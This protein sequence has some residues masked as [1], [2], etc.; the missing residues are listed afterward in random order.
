MRILF[1]V[2]KFPP[3]SDEN[4][5]VAFSLLS[6]YARREDNSVIDVVTS[7]ADGNFRQEQFSQSITLY[8]V[9]SG[10]GVFSDATYFKQAYE[11]ACQLIKQVSYDLAHAFT[12]SPC[13][14]VCV[15]IKKKF[16]IPYVVSLRWSDLEKTR[17]DFPFFYK[18]TRPSQQLIWKNATFVLS[19]NYAL[20]NAVGEID[21]AKD[22]EVIY[23]GIDT[24]VFEEFSPGVEE[25]SHLRLIT[26]PELV[27]A[28]GIRFLVKAMEVLKDQ[29]PGIKLD[30]IGQGEEEKSL[31]DLVMSLSMQDSIHFLGKVENFDLPSILSEHEVC[32]LPTLEESRV[33]QFMLSAM[34]A[35]LA[36]VTTNAFCEDEYVK[37]GINGLFVVK[38]DNADLERKLGYLGENP[39][40]VANMGEESGLVADGIVWEKIAAQYVRFYS[41]VRNLRVLG[42]N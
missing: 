12:T 18:I 5:D 34:A 27:P 9:P 17:Q 36:I 15:K 39:Q 20:R 4:G 2:P 35:R 24:S 32:V 40:A 3:M 14:D 30:I 37:D 41:E 28:N 42:R 16:G 26:G 13:G 6:Q 10:E 33:N 8:R 25:G 23:D 22:V 38:G 31:Q 11:V 29:Y 1:F 7:S 19:P 21:T